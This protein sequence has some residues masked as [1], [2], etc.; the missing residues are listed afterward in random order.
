MRLDLIAL[1]SLKSLNLSLAKLA[2]MTHAA[3]HLRSSRFPRTG[4]DRAGR[5][6]STNEAI[7]QLRQAGY[8]PT[9]IYE[10]GKGGPDGKVSRNAWRKQRAKRDRARK[11]A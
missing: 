6:R 1:S 5:S 11:S 3:F 10:E 9:N 8:F 2:N 7:G 4:I